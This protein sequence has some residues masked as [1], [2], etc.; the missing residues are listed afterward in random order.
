M[1]RRILALATLLALASVF[2]WTPA[3]QAVGY[4]SVTYCANQP[5]GKLCGCPP[6]SDKPGSPATCGS[7]KWSKACWYFASSTADLE[8]S[9]EAP[10]AGDA[11]AAAEEV[12]E[13]F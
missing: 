11:V 13:P 8:C 7:Y 9:A 12:A 3:A 4:C 6:E 10:A 5:S 2:V 1:M